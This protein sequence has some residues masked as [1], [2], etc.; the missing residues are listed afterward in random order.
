MARTSGNADIR[1]LAGPGKSKSFPSTGKK[2]SCHASADSFVLATAMLQPADRTTE[3]GGAP[4]K[5][6]R[7]AGRR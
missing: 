1:F 5:D 2:S 7:W 3:I 4:N 6:I